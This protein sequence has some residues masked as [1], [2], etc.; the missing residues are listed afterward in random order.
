MTEIEKKL[1]LEFSLQKI[2]IDE[3]LQNYSKVVDSNHVLQLLIEAYNQKD[4][5]EVEYA[6]LLGFIFNTFSNE[7]VEV[8][9]KLI[10]EEW[11]YKHEDIALVL[12]ELK[13]PVSVD[14]LYMAALKKLDYLGYDDSFALARKCIH[15]LG[16]INTESSKEKLKLLAISDILI[17]REKAEKQLNYYKR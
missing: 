9:C 15:A 16:D 4:S 2:N 5:S 10:Q 7:Y 6:L 1:I 14:A 8:L 13:S 12:Q 17:I 3:F 11:H